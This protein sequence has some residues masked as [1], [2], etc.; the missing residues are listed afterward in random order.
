[1]KALLI[2]STLTL[3][4]SCGKHHVA[5]GID[6]KDG[7]SLVALSGSI[8][9]NA[10]CPAGGVATTIYKDLNRNEVVDLDTD[11]LVSS[12]IVC[13]GLTGAQ[14]N[15]GDNGIN[16]QNGAQ[17]S[18]GAAGQ[19]GTNGINGTNGTNGAS[20]IL[21]VI[22]LRHDI[23]GESTVNFS[24]VVIKLADGRYLASFSDD[25]NGYNTRFTILV[26]GIGYQ[27]TDNTNCRF[28]LNSS[29]VL[30]KIQ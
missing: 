15:A 4:A 25:V 18:Q 11:K 5:D 27:T 3:L 8:V 28:M 1:M 16:G 23:C 19:N 2:L 21:Q 26:Q 12:F 24:E 13:N 17:G 29:N 20:S 6:G 30:V 9:A 22:N 14:G 7:Y 10:S